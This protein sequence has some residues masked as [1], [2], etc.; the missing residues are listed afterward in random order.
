MASIAAVVFG[1]LFLAAPAQAWTTPVGVSPLG[2]VAD[3]VGAEEDPTG[4]AI[5]GWQLNGM[6][7]SVIQGRIRGDDGTLGPTETIASNAARSSSAFVMEGSKAYFLWVSSDGVNDRVQ[8]R[9]FSTVG[10]FGPFL[11]PV[12]TVSPPNKDA[13]QP[14]FDVDASGNAIVAWTVGNRLIQARK[15]TAAGAVAPLD[16]V[17]PT[18]E[19]SRQPKVAVDSTGDAVILWNRSTDSSLHAVQRQGD[20]TLGPVLDLDA[21]GYPYYVVSDATGDS[22]IT[23]KVNRD[24]SKY[25]LQA[26][27]LSADGILGP[28]QLA[29]AIATPSSAALAIDPT[30]TALLAWERRSG[31]LVMRT[32]TTSGV[33][34]PAKAIAST[35]TAPD[36]GLDSSGNSVIGWNERP[37]NH[38]ETWARRRA[39]GGSLGPS[40]LVSGTRPGG[41][42]LIGLN[43][44]GD[45]I[46]AWE[47]RGRVLVSADP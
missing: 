47:N 33:L 38:Q 26:R 35:G 31:G 37:D 36:I 18:D 11:G 9:S 19:R 21:N 29:G 27:T 32:L 39:V 3:L 20:G 7:P 14:A 5:V 1:V 40:Q 28:E 6:T 22:V 17:S 16:V 10:M 41:P 4:D 46:A 30:G 45:A 23:Y 12:I 34:G 42:P 13:A 24:V 43:D 44:N 25:V 2:P 15:V 8:M